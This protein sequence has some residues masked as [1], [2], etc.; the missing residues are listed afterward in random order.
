M[1]SH[2]ERILLGAR[3]LNDISCYRFV[4]NELATSSVSNISKSCVERK[5]GSSSRAQALKN[6]S[7]PQLVLSI[8]K[9][10]AT[11]ITDQSQVYVHTI[12]QH[13]KHIT[14]HSELVLC[15]LK[16]RVST[17]HLSVTNFFGEKIICI[18]VLQQTFYL[19]TFSAGLHTK[20][21]VFIFCH[22]LIFQTHLLLSHIYYSFQ[23][24]LQTQLIEVPL[25]L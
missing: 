22:F 4:D 7:K 19:F 9:A 2:Y 3:K 14:F 25:Y 6:K 10:H 11:K 23:W 1:P 24:S 8:T 12:S 17:K 5:S 18:L 13:N 16:V 21:T 20:C 15:C